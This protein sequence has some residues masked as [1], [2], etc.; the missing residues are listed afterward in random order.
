MK[1]SLLF[2]LVAFLFIMLLPACQEDESAD[3]KIL[4][5]NWYAK[6]KNDTGFKTTSSG[7]CYKVIHQGAQRFPN[8]NSIIYAK[9]KGTLIDGT[10]FE[11][12]T[13]TFQLGSKILGLQEGI[14]KM[15]N[16]GKYIFYIPSP[17]TNGIITDYSSI[18][19]NSVLTYEVELYDSVNY[20]TY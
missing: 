7:L 20:D 6:H 9:C 14:S 16:G 15:Q 11:S 3:W 10:V 2:S 12:G 4:N 5:D 17:L 18:P 1:R 8:N 19:S 13:Y